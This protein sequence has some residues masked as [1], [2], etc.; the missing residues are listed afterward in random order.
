MVFQLHRQF[1]GSGVAAG[2][3]E[4]WIQR[5][6]RLSAATTTHA[7]VGKVLALD[8][9]FLAVVTHR[10][11]SRALDLLG[12]AVDATENAAL[13]GFL[14]LHNVSVGQ[15]LHF[16][17][18]SLGL[19]LAQGRIERCRIRDSDGKRLVQVHLH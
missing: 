18:F 13:A 6:G 19:I 8:A 11:D 14:E 9:Q 17:G 3:T 2:A 12:V 7:L 15:H 1:G 5:G 16:L 4:R 10:L